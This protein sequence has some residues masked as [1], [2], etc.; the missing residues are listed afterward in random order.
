MFN[1]SITSTVNPVSSKNSRLQH[2]SNVSFPSMPPAGTVHFFSSPGTPCNTSNTSFLSLTQTPAAPFQFDISI[3]SL[4]ACFSFVTAFPLLNK[5]YTAIS[6]Y[7]TTYFAVPGVFQKNSGQDKP[8]C[9]SKP[10]TWGVTLPFSDV[11]VPEQ[12]HV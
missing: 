10:F 7:V 2:C 9:L 8:A 5:R 12:C 11:P 3:Q 4:L 6:I 1:F